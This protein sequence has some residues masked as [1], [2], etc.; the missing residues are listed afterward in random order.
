MNFWNARAMV[1]E[2]EYSPKALKDMQELRRN[3]PKAYEKLQ[4]LIE[5][6]EEHPTTGTGK[7]HQLKGDRAGQWS[8]SIT[9]KHCLVYEIFEDRVVVYVLSALGHYDDK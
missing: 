1:Y 3:E 9:H 6:L 7:P 2:I 8:R 4:R 5:E